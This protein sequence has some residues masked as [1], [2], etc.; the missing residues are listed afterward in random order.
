LGYKYRQAIS[1][2]TSVSILI[3]RKIPQIIYVYKYIYLLYKYLLY[4]SFQTIKYSIHVVTYRTL[5]FV[6]ALFSIERLQ[7]EPLY[8]DQ[9]CSGVILTVAT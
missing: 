8:I 1:D 5:L 2:Y 7:E 6:Y 3:Y 4:I 9:K